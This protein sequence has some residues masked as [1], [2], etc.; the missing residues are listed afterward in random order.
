VAAGRTHVESIIATGQNTRPYVARNVSA[1]HEHLF[2]QPTSI[3]VLA[4]G[5]IYIEEYVYVCNSD[6]TMAVG[7]ADPGKEWVGWVPWSGEGEVIWVS[8]AGVRLVVTTSYPN[9]NR[10]VEI[11]G[12]EYPLDGVCYVNDVPPQIVDNQP[13]GQGPLYPWNGT[14]EVYDGDKPLGPRTVALGELVALPGDDFSGDD[15]FIGY[16]WVAEFEPFV[17]HVQPAQ[18]IRQSLRRRKIKQLAIAFQQS[19]GFILGNRRV[20]MYKQGED[21]SLA[22]PQRE[23]VELFKPQGRS[24]DPRIS[25]LKDTP[26]TLRILEIGIDITA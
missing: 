5:G 16:P 20:A 2:V 15:I 14:V 11:L 4:A 7:K 12:E 13:V 18:S 25:L 3:G 19:T 10:L 9:G 21:Q 8:G 17:P 23:G 22:P 26:G 24:R 6:G 1:Y